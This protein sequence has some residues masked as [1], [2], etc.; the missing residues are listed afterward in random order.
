MYEVTEEAA[1][2]I[3]PPLLVPKV[4][5]W[6]GG[7]GKDHVTAVAHGEHQ[8]VITSRNRWTFEEAHCN[9]LRANRPQASAC[10]TAVNA[11]KALEE[12]YAASASPE[13][14]DF[15]AAEERT[16]CEPWGRL[17]GPS[18][19]VTASNVGKVARHHGL[20]ILPSHHPIEPLLDPRSGASLIAEV[21]TLAAEWC[22]RSVAEDTTDGAHTPDRSS[23][24][25]DRMISALMLLGY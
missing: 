3:I 17:R 6:F 8:R 14:C 13:V 7:P 25:I 22:R 21:L 5:H 16:C 11:Q 19:C 1:E 15:C 12:V 4:A 2:C 23:D 10:D 20:V 9:A 18:G 24:L